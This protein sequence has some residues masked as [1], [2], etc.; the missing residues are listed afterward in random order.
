MNIRPGEGLLTVCHCCPCCCLW[1]VIPNLDDSI[2][3]KVTRLTGVQLKLN[4]DACK[5][6]LKCVKEACMFDSIHLENGKISINHDTCRGCGLCVNACKFDAI[7]IEYNDE[8]IDNI[9]NRM[10][11]LIE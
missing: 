11:N 10:Y 9:I 3:D 5:K 1:K 6:C 4:N 8:T 2:S 7:S